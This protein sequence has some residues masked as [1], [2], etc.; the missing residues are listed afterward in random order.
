MD[1]GLL[2]ERQRPPGED[3]KAESE[4]RG[5]ALRRREC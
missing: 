5:I 1:A 2:G 4:R 3:R